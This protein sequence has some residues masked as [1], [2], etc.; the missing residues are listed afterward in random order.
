MQIEAKTRAALALNAQVQ[1]LSRQQAVLEV[2]NDVVRSGINFL[3][4]FQSEAKRDS[5]H[6]L[7]NHLNF[8][9]ICLDSVVTG[10]ATAD[11]SNEDTVVIKEIIR[12]WIPNSPEDKT[13]IFSEQVIHRITRT[14]SILHRASFGRTSV[15]DTQ[16]AND[17]L[18]L[19]STNYTKTARHINS[20]MHKI[21]TDRY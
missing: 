14:R 1:S 21:L 9:E 19:L 13:R 6:K 7:V 18:E 12:R 5:L 16:Y 4:N 2:N 15:A 11:E 17:F 3:T 20:H 10:V 8:F